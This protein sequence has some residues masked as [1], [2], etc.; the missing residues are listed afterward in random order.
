MWRN[1][2]ALIALS[3]RECLELLRTE[4]IGRAVFTDRAMPQILPVTYSVFDDDIVL[5]TTSTSRLALASEG[6]VLAFEVDHHDP[7]TRTGWSVVVTGLA[8][9]VVDPVEQ[10]QVLSVLDPWAPGHHDM[11]LRLPS[12]VLTGR[13][14][15]SEHSP[16]PSRI[17]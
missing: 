15:V 1:E 8:V 7:E 11:L 5:A 9:Q 17:G 4:Q 2:R 14:I 3:R 6:G 13:R 10:A 12:S 16:T